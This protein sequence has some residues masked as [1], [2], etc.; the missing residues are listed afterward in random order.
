MTYT[1]LQNLRFLKNEIAYLKRKIK[2]AESDMGS[3]RSPALSGLPSAPSR[4]SQQEREVERA[5]ELRKL[6]R[7]RLAL[8][9]AELLAAERYIS[10]IE[11]SYTRLIFSMRFIDG[12]SWRKIAMTVGGG[13]SPDGM[14]KVVVRHLKKHP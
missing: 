10:G 12:F 3:L 2:E 6:Y 13:N 7:E 8:Y 5:D 14:R 1:Q 9:N 4:L 11:D